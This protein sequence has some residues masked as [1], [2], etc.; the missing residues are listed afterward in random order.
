MSS[1]DINAINQALANIQSSF[2]SIT[3]NTLSSYNQVSRIVAQQSNI[4]NTLYFGLGNIVTGNLLVNNSSNLNGTLKV[5][6]LTST[7]SSGITTTSTS[8][9]YGLVSEATS[10]ALQRTHIGFRVPGTGELGNI[11][12]A[13]SSLFGIYGLSQIYLNTPTLNTNGNLITS[14][15]ANITGNLSVTG[16]I[17]GT[18]NIILLNGNLGIG[19][20]NPTVKLQIVGD[21]KIS[22]NIFRESTKLNIPL[23][24]AVVIGSTGTWIVPSDIVRV[25]ITAIGGGGGGSASSTGG[26][27]GGGGAGSIKYLDVVPNTTLSITIGTGGG[28]GVAGGTTSVSYNSVVV[29]SAAGGDAGGTSNNFSDGGAGGN[30]SS[31]V[32]DIRVGG[33]PGATGSTGSSFAGNGGSSAFGMGSGG[34]ADV[35]NAAGAGQIYGGGGGSNKSGAAGGVIIE[36]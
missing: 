7:Q 28:A 25:K 29:C 14:G 6:A 12:T 32:G 10:S 20:T 33:S 9:T 35:N 26:S 23:F 24:N 2:N 34:K 21:T 15:N 22:G 31:G 36:Y 18:S 3:G 11:Y 1:A 13:G 17:I 4:Y 8:G 19:T 16:N 27:G 5:G 30:R